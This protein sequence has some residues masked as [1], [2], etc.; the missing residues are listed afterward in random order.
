MADGADRASLTG[1]ADRTPRPPTRKA[2]AAAELEQGHG[3]GL[4]QATPG[5][6]E[7]PQAL[8]VAD[9]PARTR[10]VLRMQRNYGNAAVQRLL[11]SRVDRSPPTAAASTEKVAV[12]IS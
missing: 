2:P 5:L 10:L 7:L 1:P 6:L 12:T 4:E 8:R 3:T 11:A 9:G